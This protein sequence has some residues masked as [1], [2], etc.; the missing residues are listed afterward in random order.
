MNYR[1]YYKEY[2]PGFNW[3][4]ND[5]HKVYCNPFCPFFIGLSKRKPGLVPICECEEI[6]YGSKY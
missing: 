2:C 1:E 6:K 3:I 4:N 5:K